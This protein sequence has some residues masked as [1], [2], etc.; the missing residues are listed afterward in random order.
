MW[1]SYFAWGRTTLWVKN[2]CIHLSRLVF[3]AALR[4]CALVP[5]HHLWFLVDCM[6]WE[7]LRIERREHTDYFSTHG[8]FSGSTECFDAVDVEFGWK[9]AILEWLA[10]LLFSRRGARW[11]A[12]KTRDCHITNTSRQKF[13]H[14]TIGHNPF[15]NATELKHAFFSF[16]TTSWF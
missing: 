11:N 3:S 15:H 1:G 12:S 13:S 2:A 9:N 4:L 8:W 5:R 7:K 14:V 6:K 16:P 10:W